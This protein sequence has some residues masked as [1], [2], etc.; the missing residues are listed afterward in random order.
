MSRLCQARMLNLPA[1]TQPE[2]TDSIMAAKPWRLASCAFCNAYE[3]QLSYINLSTIILVNKM[4]LIH[5]Y[6]ISA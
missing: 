3:I 4:L 5:S 2:K 6:R 1:K